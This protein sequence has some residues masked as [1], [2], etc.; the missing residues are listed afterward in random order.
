[1]NPLALLGLG[2]ALGIRHATDP[3]H[4]VAVMA[5]SSRTRRWLPAAGLGAVWGLGHTL[6]LF[7]VGALII[8][9]GRAHV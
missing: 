1:M 7:V 2:L 5:I 9:I 4:V 3:D 8:Q 6:T